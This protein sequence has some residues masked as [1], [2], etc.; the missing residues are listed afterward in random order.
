MQHLCVIGIQ[1]RKVINLNAFGWMHF[2]L[3]IIKQEQLHDSFSMKASNDRHII[4]GKFT[5]IIEQG[6]MQTL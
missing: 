4:I 3:Y 2:G 6:R 1:V 5:N